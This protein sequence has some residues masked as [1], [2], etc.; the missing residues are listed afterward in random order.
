MKREQVGIILF[1]LVL[2][3]GVGGIVFSIFTYHLPLSGV[4][5]VYYD[6]RAPDGTVSHLYPVARVRDLVSQGGKTYRPMIEDPVYFD[7]KTAVPYKTAR[8]DLV[9][10]NRTSIPLR[11]GMKLPE[12]GPAFELKALERGSVA[13]DLSRASYYNSKYTF[14]FSVP[15]L[16]TENTAAGEVRLA[17][18]T[19]TLERKPFQWEDIQSLW[20]KR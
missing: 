9:Y 18:M 5:R 8:I 4:K 15:G 3:V 1:R 12:G 16:R 20:K 14:V 6:F 17:E 11:I 19:L 7:V 13:F 2:A 10:E